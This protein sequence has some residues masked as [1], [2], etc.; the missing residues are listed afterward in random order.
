MEW[1]NRS[2]A[3]QKK[4]VEDACFSEGVESAV[5]GDGSQRPARELHTNETSASSIKF[6]H[7]NAFLLKVGINGA[8]DSFR[9]VAPDTALLLGKTGAMYATSL[10]RDSERDVTDS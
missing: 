7:P 6:R 1:L 2:K 5:L 10:V 4:S 9:D 3:V 8:V